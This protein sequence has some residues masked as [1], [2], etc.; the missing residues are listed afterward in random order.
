[1][2]R[3]AIKVKKLDHPDRDPATTGWCPGCRDG[4]TSGLLCHCPACHTNFGDETAF[5]KHQRISR[6]GAA[7]CK[8]PAKVKG[9]I[10][11][12]DVWWRAGGRAPARAA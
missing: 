4:W 1:M 2:A 5:D 7:T 8:D 3:F 11:S 10:R 9:L 12:G 6:A